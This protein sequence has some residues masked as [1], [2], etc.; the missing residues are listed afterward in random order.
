MEG[1]GGENQD[2]RIDEEREHQRD[3]RIP[4]CEFERLALFGR[5]FA[6]GARLYDAGMQIQVMRHDGG[7]DDAERQ[8][9][10]GRVRHD[11][12]GGREAADHL[13]PLRIGQR[14][15]HEETGED[16]PQ[17]RDDEGLDVAEAEALQPEDQ[18]HVER[19]DQHA[20]FQ[21]DAEE[22]VEA[23]RRPHHLG[24]IGGDDRYFGEQPE[25][26]GDGTRIGIAAGLRQVTAGADRK[27]RTQGLQDD[28]HDVRHQRH[29][30]QRIAELGPTRDGRR[31]VA[32]IHVA[33]GHQIAGADEGHGPAEGRAVRRQLDRPEDVDQWRLAAWPAP[34]G[35][36]RGRLGR[37]LLFLTH[38]ISLASAKPCA[39]G[40]FSRPVPGAAARLSRNGA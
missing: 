7:A 37:R 3:G 30:Q 31:P 39:I 13:P 8:I 32:R 34:A 36:F 4:R 24:D 21:R 29:R 5:A 26:E 27:A 14:D 2:R 28:G 11:L 6:I 23:D 25:H 10:H 17:Q 12:G 20:Q 22:Q 16:H 33:D 19:G 40:S 15:L 1:G 18:E 35:L 9:E 38:G